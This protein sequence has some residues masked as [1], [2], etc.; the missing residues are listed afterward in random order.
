MVER[1]LE[2][3]AAV[4]AKDV[5]SRGLGGGY[6]GGKPH[7][8]LGFRCEVHEDVDGLSVSWILCITSYGKCASVP[9]H[10]HQLVLY[11]VLFDQDCVGACTSIIC[12]VEIG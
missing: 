2:A 5:N 1:L 3:K 12:F 8:A 6:R 10:L 7:E 11:I 4:D 9:R